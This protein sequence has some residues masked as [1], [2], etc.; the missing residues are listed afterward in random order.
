MYFIFANSNS[1]RSDPLPFHESDGIY[2]CLA[3]LS[4]QYHGYR[5]EESRVGHL[6]FRIEPVPESPDQCD[7]S[8]TSLR[9]SHH[10]GTSVVGTQNRVEENQITVTICSRRR[11]HCV[12]GVH[13][14]NAF[15]LFA[16][17][18]VA[19]KSHAP[20]G[21]YRKLLVRT[22]PRRRTAPSDYGNRSAVRRRRSVRVGCG[23]S[24][25]QTL[26]P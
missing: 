17:R 24:G 22:R 3:F 19:R 18:G 23:Y 26:P 2:L 5:H 11:L 14:R 16:K 9:R 6:P 15:F 10:S 7:A 1:S 8:F 25:P 20:Y 12:S 4:D 21:N 13:C